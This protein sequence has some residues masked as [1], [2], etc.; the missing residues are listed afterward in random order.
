[1]QIFNACLLTS[2]YTA[3]ASICHPPTC[4]YESSAVTLARVGAYRQ[5]PL[6]RHT[7]F[8]LNKNTFAIA[9]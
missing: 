9:K 6:L 3:S 7:L 4:A 8:Q 2:F 1:M 5:M